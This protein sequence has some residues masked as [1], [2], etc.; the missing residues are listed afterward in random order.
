MKARANPYQE[1]QSNQIGTA[2]PRQLIVMLYDGAI[3]FLS[4]AEGYIENYKTF[5]KA[6]HNILR[7][8]DI[9]SELM[10]SLDFEKGGEIAQNLFN[11]YAWMKKE[12]I[13]ANLEKKK[14]PLTKVITMLADL[15]ETWE[16]LE[17]PANYNTQSMASASGFVAEG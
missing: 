16:R 13:E 4:L 2:D 6:N 10:V 15:K 3:R 9:L 11:L 14:E 5:D 12:L 7:A 8:Q 17:V 1:Y